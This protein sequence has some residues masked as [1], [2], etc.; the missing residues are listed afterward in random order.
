MRPHHS[1]AFAQDELW[2]YAAD[3]KAKAGK[4]LGSDNGLKPELRAHF[5]NTLSFAFP[6]LTK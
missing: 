6:P 5:L 3:F 4:Q 1:E 2:R